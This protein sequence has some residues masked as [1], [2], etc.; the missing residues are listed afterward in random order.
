MSYNECYGVAGEFPEYHFLHGHLMKY[1]HPMN[2]HLWP[3][4]LAAGRKM[5]S[6]VLEELVLE[7]E[8]FDLRSIERGTMLAS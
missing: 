3:L 7:L 1:G 6:S 8:S 2:F 4:A 5:M